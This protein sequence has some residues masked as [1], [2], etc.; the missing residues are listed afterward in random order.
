M[1]DIQKMADSISELSMAKKIFIALLLAGGF[2]IISVIWLWTQKPDFRV[3]Y[4]NLSPKDAG[5]VVEKFK[6]KNIPYEFSGGGSTLLVPAEQV[7]E[8]RLQL[9]SEGLPQGSG[10][11]FEIFDKTSLGTTEFSQKLNYRRALQGELARTITQLEEISDAR[12]HLVIPE[13]TLFSEQQEEASAAIVISLK[14]GKHLSSHQIQGIT[15]LVAGSVKGLKPGAV[16]IVD[17]KGQIRTKGSGDSSSIQMNHTQLEYR[18]SLEKELE[19]KIETILE[20]VVG[21]DKI[22]V[23]VSSLLDFRQVERTEER[24]DPDTQVVRSEQRSQGQVD[25][26]SQSAPVSGA[27]GVT[28]NT[29]SGAQ[30]SRGTSS[31]QNKSQTTSETINYEISKTI[32]RVVE[33]F[34]TIKRLSVA[35]MIDGT[36]DIVTNDDGETTRNYV[37]RG[38]EEMGKLEEIVKKTMGYSPERKDQIEVVNIPFQVG[39]ELKA[40]EIVPETIT[41]KIMKWLPLVR[42]IT[43]PLLILLVLLFITKPIMKVLLTP[44]AQPLPLPGGATTE[45]YI[46]GGLPEENPQLE[47]KKVQTPTITKENAVLMAKDNPQAATQLVK[48]WTNDGP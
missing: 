39:P 4:T 28:S 13:P 26:S 48:K 29:P 12:V 2:A 41:D 27:P 45:G 37:P 38:E 36:Y 14:P 7:H 30:G 6:E 46:E 10:V 24:F 22:V 34:G 1:A 23:R 11:G 42:Q 8:L 33:P 35:V 15:H 9:A 3:L 19:K 32:S 25:G 44:A 5:A 16:T 21:P 31:N 18:Q 40:E 43:G 17:N 20:R 47:Q